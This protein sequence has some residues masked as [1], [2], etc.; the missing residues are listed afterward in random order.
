MSIACDAPELAFRPAPSSRLAPVP[1]SEVRLVGVSSELLEGDAL[2]SRARA[3]ELRVDRRSGA[4]SASLIS[5]ERFDRASQSPA[6]T[7]SADRATGH[8][9][10]RDV[11]LE[12]KVVVTER[13]GLRATSERAQYLVAEGWLRLPGDVLLQGDNFEAVGAG[14]VYWLGTE[15][16]EV[17]PPVRARLGPPP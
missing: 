14:A 2:R 13:E 1:A 5:V 3:K 9:T 10:R 15:N 8:V 4:L 12:G 16:L 6:G 11:Q 17:A 7:L